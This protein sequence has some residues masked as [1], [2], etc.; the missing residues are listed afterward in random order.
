MK[1]ECSIIEDLL[2]LYA[3]GMVQKETAEFVKDHLEKCESCRK[4]LAQLNTPPDAKAP[5]LEAPLLHLRKKLMAKR[6]QAIVLTALLVSALLVS[7]FAFLDAPEFFPYSP[8]LMTIQENPDQSLSVTFDPAVTDYRCDSLPSGCYAIEAWTSQWD[9]WFTDPKAQTITI[10]PQ[11]ELAVFY[12]SN[13]GEEDVCIYGQMPQGT[14]GIMTLPRLTLSYYA[15]FALFSLLPLMVL[16]AAVRRKSGTR[17]WVERIMLYPV[18]YLLGHL[19]VLGFDTVSYSMTRDFSLILFIS[20]LV[21][22]GL[23]LIHSLYYRKKEEKEL[24]G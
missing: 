17:I 4:T 13:N 2:P 9:K 8:E 7:A 21:Y 23:L 5:D 10:Q 6:I 15:G 18:S 19:M 14:S 3:E 16:W 20:I 11:D 24:N 22:L 12:V 1:H